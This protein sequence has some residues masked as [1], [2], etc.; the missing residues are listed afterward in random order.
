MTVLTVLYSP[1]N[2]ASAFVVKGLIRNDV[3]VIPLSLRNNV[4]FKLLY[5]ICLKT[6]LYKLGGKFHFSPE[7]YVKLQNIRNDVLFFDCQ[8]INEYMVLISITKQNKKHLF[9][10]NPLALSKKKP[11]KILFCLNKIKSKGVKIYTFDPSDSLLYHIKLIKN[12]N[13]MILF[14]DSLQE[15]YDF[16]FLGL[17]KKREVILNFLERK[18]TEKGYIVNFVLVKSKSEYISLEENLKNSSQSACIVDIVSEKYNQTG[19]TLR[20]FDAL[21]LKKKLLTN[22]KSIKNYDFYHP[23]NIL[24]IDKDLKGLD[25][26]MKRSYHEID[27]NIVYQYEINHWI[28]QFI[29]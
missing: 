18:L 20:P 24:I 11:N 6:H 15:K 13:R 28:E 17:P 29:K 21:F 8:R 14:N 12:V 22:C 26:F 1:L 25:D 2:Q 9:F 10:W 16:Y 5:H 3:D 19:L 27:E 23:D 7:T 4:C